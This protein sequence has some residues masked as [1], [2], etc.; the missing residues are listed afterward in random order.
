MAFQLASKVSNKLGADLNNV[1]SQMTG[2]KIPVEIAPG[3][4]G[5]KGKLPHPKTL[6]NILGAKNIPKEFLKDFNPETDFLTQL[7]IPPVDINIPTPQFQP[8]QPKVVPPVNEEEL[9]AQGMSDEDIEKEK[10]KREARQ[11]LNDKAAEVQNK[12][13][14]KAQG[15]IENVTGG[16]ESAI[17]GG[18][19]G[20]IAGAA[21][22]IMGSPLGGILLKIKAFNYF[23]SQIGHVSEEVTSMKEDVDKK[24]KE[25]TKEILEGATNLVTTVKTL[26]KVD[27]TVESASKAAD[28]D[29]SSAQ[30]AEAAPADVKGAGQITPEK[31]SKKEELRAKRKAFAENLKQTANNVGKVLKEVLGL[32]KSILELIMMVVGAIMAIIALIAFLMQLLAMIM[33]MCI[34]RDSK[35]NS[36]GTASPNSQSPEQ[37]L[38]DI[39][40]PGYGEIDFDQL[41]E[42]INLELINVPTVSSPNISVPNTENEG[43]NLGI[44]PDA[45]TLPPLPSGPQV[46]TGAGAGTGAGGP[47]T[48]AGGPGTGGPTPTGTGGPTVGG[49]GTG[50]GLLSTLTDEE[51]TAP[52]EVGGTV[53]GNPLTPSDLDPSSGKNFNNHPLLGDVSNIHPQILNELYNEGIIPSAETPKPL[54]DIDPNNWSEQLE[55]YYDEL[56]ED[57]KREEQIEYIDHLYNLKSQLIGYTRYRA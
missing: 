46:G 57:V 51:L 49:Q 6:K 19:Q 7:G 44:A 21:G 22:A 45:P 18:V 55:D 54:S 20:A 27:K 23:K 33:M 26:K 38:H 11:K 53:L 1:K 5:L 48:G 17:Q 39:G 4:A 25:K 29:A 36:G 30:A 9:R 15:L 2:G 37:F 12:V 42:D 28:A 41:I 10:F 31:T 16:I 24:L 32:V 34:K 43:I 40:Y 14:D 35:M 56:V 3:L 13:K 8:T 50:G 47:G 52:L